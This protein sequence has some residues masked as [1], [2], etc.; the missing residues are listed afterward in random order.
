MNL[1]VKW[2]P[3][4]RVFPV[5]CYRSHWLLELSIMIAQDD[6]G[7]RLCALYQNVVVQHPPLRRCDWLPSTPSL[8]NCHMNLK[9]YAREGSRFPKLARHDKRLCLFKLS[10]PCIP[11]PFP[12]IVLGDFETSC[13]FIHISKGIPLY[14]LAVVQQPVKIFISLNFTWFHG[15]RWCELT[16]AE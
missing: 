7:R 2:Y 13:I 10:D 11:D 8:D 12:L 5:L 6:F 3:G 1:R 16:F 14:R 4:I 15:V 9:P